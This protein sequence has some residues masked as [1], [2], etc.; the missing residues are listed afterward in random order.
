[1]RVTRSRELVA[2]GYR[3]AAVARVAQISRQAIYRVPKPRRAPAAPARPPADAVEAAIVAEAE[4]NPTDGYRLV[5]AWVRRRLGRAVNRKRVLRVMRERRL[6][7]RPQPLDRRRRPGFFR[8][9]RPDQLWH[10]DM[11]SVWVAEHGWVY[12]MAAIDCCTREIVAWQLETR[13]RAR[14]AIALIERAT[15]ERRRAR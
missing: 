2:E 15:L 13:C 10:L 14:E 7:Q 12:L 1:M 6:I 11:T 8:V 5:T 3:S 9:E 4:A